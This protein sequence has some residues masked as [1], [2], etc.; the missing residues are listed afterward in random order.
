MTDDNGST[1]AARQD[2]VRVLELTRDPKTGLRRFRIIRI[3]AEAN[4]KAREEPV[5][6]AALLGKPPQGRG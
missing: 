4:G 1:P 5:E 3:P 6:K 2:G